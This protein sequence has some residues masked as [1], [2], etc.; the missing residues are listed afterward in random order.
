[1]DEDTKLREAAR[2]KSD[3]KAATAIESGN[4]MDFGLILAGLVLVI[5]GL[6]VGYHILKPK[7]EE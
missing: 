6:F 5:L 2:N 7:Q 3:A 4:K 1:M